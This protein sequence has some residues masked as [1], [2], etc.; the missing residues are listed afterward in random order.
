MFVDKGPSRKYD[1]S[2]I[3]HSVLFMKQHMAKIAI[4]IDSHL[5]L[6]LDALVEKHYF[7]NRSQA[8][9]QV[10]QEQ[11]EKLDHQRLAQECE[12]LDIHLEQSL[13]DEGLSKDSKEWPDY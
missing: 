13:A 4:T 9:Q 8:I 10:M 1:N 6:R 5:L 12:K 11:I 2:M 3:N 7:K